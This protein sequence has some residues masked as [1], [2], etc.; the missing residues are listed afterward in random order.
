MTAC[1]TRTS[2]IVAAPSAR[3]NTKAPPASRSSPNKR[4]PSRVMPLFGSFC[5]HEQHL[6]TVST[7]FTHAIVACYRKPHSFVCVEGSDL[8]LGKLHL[9]YLSWR[10]HQDNVDWP[11]YER[12]E[13]SNERQH[14]CPVG[15]GVFKRTRGDV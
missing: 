10:S 5:T 1:T 15:A 8:A 3:A 6:N 11:G 12:D 9:V 14:F 13:L 7:F 2:T 4:A